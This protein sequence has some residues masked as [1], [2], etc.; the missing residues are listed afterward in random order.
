MFDELT[1]NLIVSGRKTVTRRLRKNEK[2]PAKPNK[3]IKLKIDRT[4]NTFGY[5]QIISCEKDY[6]GNLKSID[7]IKEG[8][9]SKQEY[10]DYFKKVNG[11]N[12]YKTPIWVITFKY[13]S[14]L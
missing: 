2:R 11:T 6:L 13:L 10:L 1:K 8:F 5:L 12:Y 14:K 3:I 4:K 7:A 9:N